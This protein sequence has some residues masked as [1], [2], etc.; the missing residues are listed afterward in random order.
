MLAGAW[1][2]LAACAART[3]QAQDEPRPPLTGRD[4]NIDLVTGPVLGSG[5]AVGLGGAYTALVTGADG[6]SWNA[7]SYAAR[8]HWDIDWFEW[9]LTLN[10]VSGAI[11][12]SDFDNN[13]ESGFTYDTFLF[14]TLGVCLQFGAFGVGGLANVQSYQ[15]AENRELLLTIYN[16]AASYAFAQG[17]LVVGLGL[18]TA[19]LTIGEGGDADPLVDV[20]GTGPEAGALL[21]V[22][23]QPFR[24]G[25]AARMPV[26][27]TP[28]DALVA[29]GLMLPRHIHLPWEI[30]VGAA[31]QLGPRPLNRVWVNPHDVS[32]RLR[33]ELLERRRARARAQYERESQDARMQLAQERTPPQ[34]GAGR[35]PPEGT[36]RDPEFWARESQLRSEEER[37]MRAEH[38]R[39]EAKRKAAYEALSRRYLLLSVETIFV[40]PT[41]NGV[42]VESFLSNR[43]HASGRNVSV[44]FRAGIEGEPVAHWLQMRAGTYFEPS[45][46]A[47]V[48]YRAHGTLGADVRLFSWDL[49]GLLD[50]FTLR[51]GASADVAERYLNLGFGLGLWH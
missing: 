17:Q 33:S 22:E 41:E 20:A 44:G 27:T 51:A 25:L 40:G 15:I 30:Q 4:F 49:F 14:G 1:A 3:A 6:G 28:P 7:A 36:P 18:R 43:E 38:E 35:P 48:P 16:Y 46:F 32:R 34:V 21:R 39:L 8:G 24:L 50:E 42:G 5:R 47:R 12:D 2:A 9:E 19:S 23:G 10:M 11:R 29:A 26:E 45:R 31:L 37:V 13:G